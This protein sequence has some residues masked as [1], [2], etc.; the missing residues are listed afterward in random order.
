MIKISV[1]SQ[2][3]A[4]IDKAT[5]P[6]K[7]IAAAIG[8]THQKFKQL[9][10]T[11][12]KNLE[13]SVGSINPPPA[14]FDVTLGKIAAIA[15][16]WFSVKTVV[17]LVKKSI[18]MS[19]ELTL[20]ETRLKNVNL[21]VNSLTDSAQR[22]RVD[23]KN[24]ADFTARIGFNAGD[25]FGDPAELI[26]F[27][28][29]LS[30]QFKLSGA[31][32]AEIESATVQL[33]QALG[34]GVLRG[35]E[36]A[37]V[38][39]SAPAAIQAIAKHLGV[40]QASLKK[41]A[42]Q[43]LIT[44]DVVKNAIL[45]ASE[46][47]DAE[48]QKI[49]KTFSDIATDVKN[50]ALISFQPVAQAISNIINTDDFQNIVDKVVKG[51]D[52]AAQIALPLIQAIGN[53]LPT[54]SSGL[55]AIAA[56]IDR[57]VISAAAL[58]VV[59][60]ACTGP[61]GE[62]AAAVIGLIMWITAIGEATQETSVQADN[63]FANMAGFVVR[64]GATALNTAVLLANVFL[65]AY[66]SIKIGVLSVEQVVDS[67]FGNILK[68]AAKTAEGVANF[69]I[70]CWNWVKKLWG[71]EETAHVKFSVATDTADALLDGAKKA[72]AERNELWKNLSNWKN[73]KYYLQT[74]DVQNLRDKA[75]GW[76]NDLGKN[77]KIDTNLSPKLGGF[78]GIGS[79][80][81]LS[82]I[83]RGIGKS[84]GQTAKNTASIDKN[85]SSMEENLKILRELQMRTVVTRSAP[86]NINIQMTNNQNFPESLS[87]TGMAQQTTDELLEVLN[88]ALVQNQS[89]SGLQVVY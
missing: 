43:G 18:N 51:I 45:S 53:S 44:A 58:G 52:I 89:I 78:T 21:S 81:N 73:D 42:D 22:A 72:G 29:T 15:A 86:V 33:S 70:D 63:A 77:T 24:M 6:L 87:P 8:Q 19:D 16:A 4:I 79:S 49:P 40:P 85:I 75:V 65:S 12:L 88:Q 17:D 36:F 14:I 34:A 20:L 80:D 68:W 56:N 35:Q 31:T 59:F 66:N 25:L 32:S 62:L 5:T 76:A 67:V 60:L 10:N 13:K 2:T 69:F 50:Q 37:S 26:K 27:S 1:L 84:A 11:S 74:V 82:N 39:R 41:L 47:V 46:D 57:I 9:D 83:G 3:I 71:G 38:L 61:V 30:K 64:F 55:D 23:L 7:N 48:F 28:E 54:I